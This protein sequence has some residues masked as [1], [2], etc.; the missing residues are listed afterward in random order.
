M[1]CVKLMGAQSAQITAVGYAISLDFARDHH[2]NAPLLGPINTIPKHV[3]A[4]ASRTP[5]EDGM[6]IYCYPIRPFCRIKHFFTRNQVGLQT[7]AT[8]LYHEIQVDVQL[9][10]QPK[11]PGNISLSQIIQDK[12]IY[13]CRLFCSFSNP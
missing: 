6:I 13:V 9:R 12:L 11:G 5:F 1:S 4:A 2:Q 10:R 7:E 3:L 8:N